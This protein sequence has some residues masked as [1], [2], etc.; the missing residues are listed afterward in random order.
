MEHVART[1]GSEFRGFALLILL[2]V[3]AGFGVVTLIRKVTARARGKGKAKKRAG[4]R[5]GKG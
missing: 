3:L 2:L 5:Q 4:N 1:I